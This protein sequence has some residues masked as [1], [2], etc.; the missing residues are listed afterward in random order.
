MRWAPPP[1]PLARP[2]YFVR[3]CVARAAQGRVALRRCSPKPA[4]RTGRR[5]RSPQGR[6]GWRCGP[7]GP[8]LSRDRGRRRRA[9]G[10]DA[11]SSGPARRRAGRTG[12]GGGAGPA[13]ARAASRLGRWRAAPRRGRARHSRF[14]PGARAGRRRR[15]HAGGRDRGPVAPRTRTDAGPARRAARRRRG[16]GLRQRRDAGNALSGRPVAHPVLRRG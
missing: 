14:R 12:G 3:R 7:G 11:G 1:R 8:G 10:P 9:C 16:R 4:R 15:R 13:G 2:P 6:P 5:L